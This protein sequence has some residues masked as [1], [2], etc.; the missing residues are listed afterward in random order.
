MTRHSSTPGSEA[1]DESRTLTLVDEVPE[2]AMV[3]AAHPDDA[4]IGPGATVGKWTALG[5]EVFYVVCT[6]GGGGR[7]DH[8]PSGR[9]IISLRTRRSL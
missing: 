6:T 2:R 9:T 7:N 3:V 8:R 4:E 1:P 5:C